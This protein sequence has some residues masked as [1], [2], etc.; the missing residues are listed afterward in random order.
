MD[1][2]HENSLAMFKNISE[3]ETEM[4]QYDSELVG[5]ISGPSQVKK[6]L[7]TKSFKEDSD[8]PSSI[9]QKEISKIS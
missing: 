4:A 3:F 6:S 8:L 5:I 1:T 9:G 2:E 7:V